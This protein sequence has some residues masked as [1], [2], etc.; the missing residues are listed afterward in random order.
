MHTLVCSACAGL[1]V[2]VGSE[3][4]HLSAASFPS[5]HGEAHTH[6]HTRAHGALLLNSFLG[7]DF[8]SISAEDHYVCDGFRCFA[9]TDLTVA[10]VKTGVAVI[11]PLHM[12]PRHEPVE[13]AIKHIADFAI[14]ELRGGR[15][16][17]QC[18]VHRCRTGTKV[19]PRR[20]ES[21]VA[22]FC[23]EHARDTHLCVTCFV[24]WFFQYTPP[25]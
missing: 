2:V 9:A 5:V 8:D 21:G 1:P 7:E 22:M 11:C 12:Y 17:F 13:V 10:R 24:V 18:A 6:A 25:R 20:T 16:S 15:S 4:S 23:V 14:Q 3:S 19:A